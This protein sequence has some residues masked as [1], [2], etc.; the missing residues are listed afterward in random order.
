[1]FAGFAERGSDVLV[2][3]PLPDQT[4]DDGRSGLGGD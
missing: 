3:R 1:M 4:F 2:A